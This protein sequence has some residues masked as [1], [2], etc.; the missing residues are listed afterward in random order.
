[1][2]TFRNALEFDAWLSEHHGDRDEVWLMIAKKGSAHG[3]VTIGEAGD[4]ALCHGWIDSRRKGFD[5]DFYLQRFSPRRAGSP[6]SQVNV[7]RV[8]RLSAEG[9]MRPAGLA[10]VDKAKAD[11][12]WDAAYAPQATAEVPADL[13]ARLEADPRARAAFDA[14]GKT[15]RYLVI[16]DLLKARTPEVRAT[17]LDRALAALIRP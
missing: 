8:E 2:E 11:G 16:L 3:T 15:E 5:A 10:E 14:L 12:R 7:R 1:M 6:W 17:R 13:Q 4:V 9:R